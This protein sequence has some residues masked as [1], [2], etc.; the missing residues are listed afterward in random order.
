MGICILSDFPWQLGAGGG[1]V[2]K[3]L[4][5]SES[6]G[7]KLIEENRSHRDARSDSKTIKVVCNESSLSPDLDIHKQIYEKKN[8]DDLNK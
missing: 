7:G 5:R 1:C 2:E 4:F 8:P 3:K 6:N